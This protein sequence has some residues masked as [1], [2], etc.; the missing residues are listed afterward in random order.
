MDFVS[1]DYDYD[2]GRVFFATAST[3]TEWPYIGVVRLVKVVVG[4][5]KRT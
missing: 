2:E 4:R 5:E 3:D 1:F